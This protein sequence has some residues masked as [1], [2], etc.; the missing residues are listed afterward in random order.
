[1]SQHDLGQGTLEP[2]ITKDLQ[3]PGPREALSRHVALVC[4]IVEEKLVQGLITRPRKVAEGVGS[5][6]RPILPCRPAAASHADALIG[7]CGYRARNVRKVP[8]LLGREPAALQLKL[9][10]RDHAPQTSG[11]PETSTPAHL[12]GWHSWRLHVTLTTQLSKCTAT[13]NVQGCHLSMLAGVK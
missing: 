9:L 5:L 13:R 10:Q 6:G 8:H 3:L 2:H 4:V 1:M 7:V 12:Q 11:H